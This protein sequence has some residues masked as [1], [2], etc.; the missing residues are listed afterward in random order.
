MWAPGAARVKAT[1]LGAC[2]GGEGQ[3]EARVRARQRSPDTRRRGPRPVAGEP[4]QARH[5]RGAVP[6]ADR[7]STTHPVPRRDQRHAVHRLGDR[8]RSPF[9]P[10]RTGQGTVASLAEAEEVLIS[11]GRASISRLHGPASRADVRDRHLL[12]SILGQACG[13]T[14]EVCCARPRSR[15]PRRYGENWRSRRQRPGPRAAWTGA[16]PFE[17]ELEQRRAWRCPARE[18]MRAAE[19]DPSPRELL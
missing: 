14:P 19:D 12:A 15:S 13:L 7:T 18:R 17:T 6:G 5:R 3:A 11:T 10:V 1:G 4:A 2:R 8:A 9:Q 16:R